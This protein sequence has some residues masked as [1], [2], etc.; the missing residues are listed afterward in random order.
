MGPEGDRLSARLCNDQKTEVEALGSNG[1]H[2][3]CEA[4]ELNDPLSFENRPHRGWIRLHHAAASLYLKFQ[5]H[6]CNL[7]SPG[8]EKTPSRNW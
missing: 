2:S 7:R 6:A 8:S 4:S 1:P 3:C 5:N